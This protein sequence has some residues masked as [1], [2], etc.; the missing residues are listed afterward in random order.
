MSPNFRTGP[1]HDGH[2]GIICFWFILHVSPN[3][4]C[5][6]NMSAYRWRKVAGREGPGLSTADRQAIHTAAASA[7]RGYPSAY[8]VGYISKV[9]ARGL[10]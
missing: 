8:V 3:T 9:Y 2:G 5:L 4:S 7:L 6:L 10:A 1:V